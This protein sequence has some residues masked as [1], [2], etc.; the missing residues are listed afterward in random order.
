VSFILVNTPRYVKKPFRN[1]II[2]NINTTKQNDKY[3]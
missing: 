2:V 3:K 1:I